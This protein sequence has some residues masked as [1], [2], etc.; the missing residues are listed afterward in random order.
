MLSSICEAHAGWYA[1][2]PLAMH[3]D[4][5]RRPPS[6]ARGDTTNSVSSARCPAARK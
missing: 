4:E 2:L 5:A 6:R 1:L 3:S